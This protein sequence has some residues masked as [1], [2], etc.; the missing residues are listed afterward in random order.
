MC[1]IYKLP[2]KVREDQ[3]YASLREKSGL[4]SQPVDQYPT[5][6]EPMEIN[7]TFA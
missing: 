4:V 7:P 5:P 6:L 2:F 1:N 3:R